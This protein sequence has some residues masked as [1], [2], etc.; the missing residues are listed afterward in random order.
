M[1]MNM[2]PCSVHGSVPHV[3]LNVLPV[4]HR[5]CKIVERKR[6]SH[7]R[8]FLLLRVRVGRVSSWLSPGS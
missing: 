6:K 3:P 4:Y 5:K 8:P 1:F 2:Y 7:S